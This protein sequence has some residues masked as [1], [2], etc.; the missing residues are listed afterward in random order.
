[1]A[2]T[3]QKAFPLAL[4]AIAAVLVIAR[5]LYAPAEPKGAVEWLTPEAGMALARS[6]GK[7]ILYDFTAEWCGPCHILD[8]QVFGDPSM[9]AEISERFVPIRVTD[10]QREDGQNTPV[11]AELQ[12]R[13]SVRGFPTVVF[14]DSSGAEQGRME[15]FAGPVRFRQVM[16][17]AGER[18]R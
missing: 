18:V 15:G 16:N 10:R 3:D 5:F 12:Q 8:A 6:S 2:R 7:P 14:T 9:A 11:V 13:Y 4:T 1:M 17:Q